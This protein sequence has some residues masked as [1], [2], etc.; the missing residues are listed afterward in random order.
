MSIVLYS[1]VNATTSFVKQRQ[2]LLRIRPASNF[3]F[4]IILLLILLILLLFLF[5]FF[6][7][8]LCVPFWYFVS[9]ELKILS[10]VRC[11]FSFI[12]HYRYVVRLNLVFFLVLCRYTYV[13]MLSKVSFT[14]KKKQRINK[15]YPYN[16][17]NHKHMFDDF[18]YSKAK[19]IQRLWV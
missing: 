18:C 5:L 17:I 19:G 8:L 13:C 2:T 1:S 9:I 12:F 15:H 16:C 7:F 6:S 10:V 3:L 4:I 14:N 11:F